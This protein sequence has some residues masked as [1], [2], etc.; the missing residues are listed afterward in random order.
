MARDLRGWPSH[1]VV[2][3]LELLQSAVVQ[4]SRLFLLL[5]FRSGVLVEAIADSLAE[6][7]NSSMAASLRLL[8]ANAL[9]VLVRVEGACVGRQ[10]DGLAL[11]RHLSLRPIG[12][13]FTN[14]GTACRRNRIRVWDTTPSV[15]SLVEA[16]ACI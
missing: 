9:V 8:V 14:I 1:L 11:S 13:S 16:N 10:L 6:R 4:S 2:G 15:G 12:R 7:V 3:L 5:V